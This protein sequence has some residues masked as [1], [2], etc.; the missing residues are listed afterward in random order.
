MGMH[1]FFLIFALTIED[2]GKSLTCTHNQCLEQKKN[3]NN[4]NKNYQNLFH[5]KFSIFTRL[6]NLYNVWKCFRNNIPEPPHGKTNNLHRRKQRRRS[7]S[8]K[9]RS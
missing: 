8:Q 5:Q 1:I 4:N 6:K 7:A 3:N 2:C 9:L